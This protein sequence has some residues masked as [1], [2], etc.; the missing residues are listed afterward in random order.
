MTMNGLRLAGIAGAAFALG[1]TACGASQTPVESASVA[2]PRAS[3]TDA[4]PWPDDASA[5]SSIHSARFR[6]SIPLPDAASWTIDDAARPELVAT[7]AL[8]QSTV[9]VRSEIEPTLVNHAKCDERART[10]GLFP[11]E[12]RGAALHTVEDVVTVGPEAYDTHIRVAIE[13]TTAEG[14]IRGHVFAAGAY[15]RKCLFVHVS[16]EVPTGG[17]EPILSARLALARVRTLGG[18][19]VDELGAVKRESPDPH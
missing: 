11:D 13:A 18:I 4:P 12:A 5:W 19:R 17:G 14:P 2:H 3:H 15:V 7:H 9:V 10:L 16:T 6:M 1:A 8:T